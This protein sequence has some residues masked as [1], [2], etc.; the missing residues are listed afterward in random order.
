MVCFG[1]HKFWAWI[2]PLRS[3]FP[4]S[5]IRGHGASLPWYLP[6]ALLFDFPC[7]ARA[8]CMLWERRSGFTSLPRGPRIHWFQRPTPPPQG[9]LCRKWNNRRWVGLPLVSLLRCICPFTRHTLHSVSFWD[10]A[11]ILGPPR[12]CPRAQP[13]SRACR[14]LPG[15][16]FRGQSMAHCLWDCGQS[17][18]VQAPGGARWC[19]C[20]KNGGWGVAVATCSSP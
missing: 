12:A 5:C 16:P 18:D 2:F 8:L 13:T 14:P 3:L 17:S 7:L 20:G 11:W 15:P 4:V 19:W 9:W 6:E 10:H 1:Q